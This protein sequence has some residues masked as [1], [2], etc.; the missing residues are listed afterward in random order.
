MVASLPPDVSIHTPQNS[1]EEA[2]LESAG[3]ELIC[4]K[5]ETEDMPQDS[6]DAEEMEEQLAEA[7]KW[8]NRRK[9]SLTEECL[10]NYLQQGKSKFQKIT[11]A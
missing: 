6:P 1:Q 11:I 9:K 8:K 2:M 3:D 10:V 4:N 7:E 5:K